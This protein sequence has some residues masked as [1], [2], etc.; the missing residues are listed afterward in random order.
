[1]FTFK[2]RERGVDGELKRWLFSGSCIHGSDGL[3]YP[4]ADGV[5]S[6]TVPSSGDLF[7]V[8]KLTNDALVQEHCLF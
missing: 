8:Q 5:S 2:R 7:N 4:F 3:V 1:M 6:R